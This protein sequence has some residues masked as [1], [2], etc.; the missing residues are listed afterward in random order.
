MHSETPQA[1]LQ[2]NGIAHAVRGRELVLSCPVC[3][4]EG[5]LF[6]STTTW[7][8]HCKRCDARGN[9]TTLKL[10]LGLQ[11]PVAS[12]TTDT[13]QTLA[14]RQLAR[15]LQAAAQRTD[16]ERWVQH[17]QTHPD[18]APARAYVQQRGLSLELCER[19]LVGWCGNPDGTTP[20]PRRRQV[21]AADPVG[22]GWLVLP[23]ATRWDAG[24]PQA[25]SVAMV[26]LRSVPPAQRAFRRL[27][28][29]DSVLFAPTGV[30]PS[31]TLLLVGGE[32]DALSCVAAGWH[33]VASSTVGE[34]N[35]TEGA[36]AQLEACT[37]IVVAYDND[38]AGKAGAVALLEKLGPHR[39]RLGSWPAGVKDANDALQQLGSK[40][41]VAA[42]VRAAV[43]AGGD[44]VVRV[45][46]LRDEYLRE[47]R[48]GV[49]RGVPSGWPDLDKLVGGVR[50]GEVTVITGDTAS[51]KSTFT[52]QFA[53]NMARQ[54]H[55]VLFCPFEL[56]AR[57]QLAKL[58]RQW[59]GM[60]PDLLSETKLHAT[61]DQLDALPL[62][63]LR[64]YGTIQREAMRNTMLHCI[65]R[66][67]VQVVV[68][69]HLH[70]MVTE[71]PDERVE[72]DAMM[73]M[74]AE[75]AVDTK[76][77]VVVVA[78]PRQHH[79]SNETH[80]DNRIIQASDLKGSAGLKQLADNVWSVWR[81][82]KADRSDAKVSE[83]HGTAVLYVLKN[84]DDYGME[85]SVAF[86]FGLRSATFESASDAPP[87]STTVDMQQHLDP[88]PTQRPRR[89][90]A[91]PAAPTTT[92]TVQPLPPV[93]RHWAETGADD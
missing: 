51:G 69:D 49:P 85:G 25:D 3:S 58:V 9:E 76:V 37:D 70:F 1:F 90:R 28:G 84:R 78:H 43:A 40:F 63:L 66:L 35:W 39:C 88:V 60:P 82:R 41:D 19:Y 61:L 27:Q 91:V 44:S 79:A 8:Y 26:K 11:Y 18:A 89:L 33:N 62:Y 73:K 30:D 53:L 46:D 38:A 47:L 13:V 32:I 83:T 71:G 21:P 10:A 24:T 75:I 68:L 4:K 72:L 17:L 5:H 50:W 67:G 77:H 22:P 42:V 57:R 55:P 56:G 64:R 80:R 23:A 54:G 81:P 7:L 36:T 16:V 12:T 48:S 2:R 20:A 93:T 6:L 29:G 65:R 31:T 15:D 52:S 74:V 92:S 34:P 14:E 45:S 86:K 59:A 87:A